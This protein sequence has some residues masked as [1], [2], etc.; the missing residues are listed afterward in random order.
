[1]TRK[2]VVDKEGMSP[3][4]MSIN[5]NG[6]RKYIVTGKKRNAKRKMSAELNAYCEELY[7]KCQRIEVTLMRMGV[8]VTMTNFMKMYKEGTVARTVTSVYDEVI[9]MKGVHENEYNY[10]KSS[11]F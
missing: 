5:I 4:L 2:S 3:V 6:E 11:S 10:Y 9:K 1:M 7:A 8:T